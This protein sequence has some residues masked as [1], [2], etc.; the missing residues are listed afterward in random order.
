MLGPYP[1]PVHRLLSWLIR[2][3]ELLVCSL[4]PAG[5]DALAGG[6]GTVW[7]A[8]DG[9]RRRRCRANLRAALEA[10]PQEATV[11]AV[12]RNMARVPLESLWLPRL[13]ATPAQVERRCVLH[14]DWEAM[15]PLIR[16]GGV[17][18]SGHLGN[19]EL[20]TH[21][22]RAYGM[23]LSFVVRPFAQAVLEQRLA[24]SRGGTTAVIPHHRLLSGVRSALR[25]QRW[26]GMLGDQNAGWNARFVPFFGIPA[27]TAALPAWIAVKER[28][29]LFLCAALRRATPFTYDVYAYR[30]P[31]EEQAGDRDTITQWVLTTY[32][33]TLA[34]WIRKAPAQYNWLHRRW[35]SRPPS[36]TIPPPRLPRYDHHRPATGA[37]SATA[38]S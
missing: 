29:P 5:V 37:P 11:R 9:R 2:L 28:V 16:D 15:R 33:E 22:L 12:F 30:V 4:P 18:L 31:L 25:A 35:K 13:F 27:S 23:K 32:M 34:S 3:A 6:A 26:V 8:L 10:E 38:S 21:A 1:A 20:G 36:E 17:I 24:T 14:G 7:Y 19:W